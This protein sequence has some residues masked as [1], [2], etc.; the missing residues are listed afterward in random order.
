M[1]PKLEMSHED[2]PVLPSRP[3]SAMFHVMRNTPEG[4]G[5]GAPAEGAGGTPLT[6]PAAEPPKT[7]EDAQRE[8]NK[9]RDALHK[10]NKEA[11]TNRKK[12][13]DVEAK[14]KAIKDAQLTET[15]RAKQEALEVKGKLRESQAALQAE[16]VG[17]QVERIAAELKFIN[18]DDAARFLDLSKVVIDDGG[19][20]SGVKEQLVALAKDRPYLVKQGGMP[21]GTP[22]TPN[23]QQFGTPATPPAGNA[24]PR[25]LTGL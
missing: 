8:L 17:R 4:D 13:A 16:R 3:Q 22:R 5:T 2:L 1:P 11:E 14:E 23:Q 7:L 10:A 15:E 19:T 18:A 6:P 25:K 24:L 9:T 20:V 12:L 21:A